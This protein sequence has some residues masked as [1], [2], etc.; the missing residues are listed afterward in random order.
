MRN[1]TLQEGDMIYIAGP[2]SGR[3]NLNKKAFATAETYLQERGYGT[4]NPH[5]FGDMAKTRQDNL[6][7]CL[8]HL[9]ISQGVYFLKGWENSVGAK[10]E[11][12]CAKKLGKIIM[13]EHFWDE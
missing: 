3:E 11:F 10:L 5:N 6:A 8:A 4:M 9:Q 12:D 7:V 2:M 13:F 1:V